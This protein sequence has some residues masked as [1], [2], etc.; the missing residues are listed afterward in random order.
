MTLVVY[1]IKYFR[2]ILRNI[3]FYKFKVVEIFKSLKQNQDDLE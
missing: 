2:S 3:Y 1:G